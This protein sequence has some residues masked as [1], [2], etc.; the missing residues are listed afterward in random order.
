MTP[1]ENLKH[2]HEMV[3]LVLEAAERESRSIRETG[4][5]HVPEIE[6]MVDFFKNFVDRCH[7]GKEERHLFPRMEARGLPAGAGPVAVMLAEHEQGRAA[8]R[9]INAALTRVKGGDGRAADELAG[10]LTDYA[11]L[12][13]N[14]IFKENNVLFPMADQM[15]STEDQT[16]LAD[17]FERVEAEEIGEGVHEKYHQLAHRLGS[18]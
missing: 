16:E 10:A 3:L 6:E 7:H 1:T 15:L 2:E 18:G 5:A 12:L 13:R 14:H 4:S 9:A 17:A 8:V 11:E